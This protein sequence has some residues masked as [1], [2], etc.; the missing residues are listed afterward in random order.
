M[1]NWMQVDERAESIAG[2]LAFIFLGLTQAALLIAIFYQRYIQ[3][4]PPAYYNDLAVILA[5]SI[6]GFWLLSFYLGGALPVLSL[7]SIVAAYV[8]LVA[9]TGLPHTII[10]GLPEGRLLADRLLI[11]FGA[12]AVLVGGYAL[13]AALGQRR[14]DRMTGS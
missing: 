12:P 2:R 10:R 3:E 9:A 14:L 5:G 1:R 7:R 4:L 8:I 11:I 13:V 6:L